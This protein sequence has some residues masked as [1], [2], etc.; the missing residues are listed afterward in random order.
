MKKYFIDSN[1]II[2]TCKNN[3]QAKAIL[4][5]YSENCFTYINPIV[6]SEVAYILKKKLNINIETVA[7]ILHEFYML[8]VGKEVI[9]IAFEYMHQYNIKP[10]DAIIAATCKHYKIPNLMTMDSDFK[11]VCNNENIFLINK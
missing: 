1:I 6:V 10:N 2:E 11:N 9:K 7:L 8:P 5:K 3:P 4:N